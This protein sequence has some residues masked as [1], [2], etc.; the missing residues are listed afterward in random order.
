MDYG[1]PAR[2]HGQP[3]N[4]DPGQDFYN[5]FQNVNPEVLNLGLR[6]GQNMIN[7]Q[8][9]RL[10]PGVSVLWHSLKIYFAVNNNFVLKKISLLLYPFLNKNWNRLPIEDV[11]NS[12]AL[13]LSTN[14]KWAL[15]RND[16]NAPDLYIPL[17]S[18]ITYILLVGYVKGTTNK[19]TPEVLIRS[20]WVCLA[21]HFLE[22]LMIKVGL[23]LMQAS[24]PFLDIIS[25]TGYKYVGL[26]VSIL[27]CGFG[28]AIYGIVSLYT[29]LVLS[30]VVL[31]SMAAAVP[32]METQGPPRH[33]VLLAFALLHFLIVCLLSWT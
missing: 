29:A 22:V 12:D 8:R 28:K 30:F 9:D 14:H 18:F 10:M 2:G 31:K 6:A 3:P 1:Q 17:M 33:L 7:M 15:P 5:S 20:I 4:I 21:L 25:Y 13:T 19:F 23:N 32:A 11:G 16:I 24:V 26:C 27:L